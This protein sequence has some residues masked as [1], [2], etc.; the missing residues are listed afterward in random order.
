MRH[1]TDTI[2]TKLKGS[3]TSILETINNKENIYV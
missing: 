3:A 1:I 2:K